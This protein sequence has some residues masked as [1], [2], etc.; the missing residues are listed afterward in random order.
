MCCTE[1]LIVCGEDCSLGET[2]VCL[3][4]SVLKDVFVVCSPGS[5]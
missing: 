4:D 3:D 5:V 2:D 1:E